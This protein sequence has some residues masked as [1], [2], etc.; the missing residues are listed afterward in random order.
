HKGENLKVKL[1]HQML[2]YHRVGTQQSQDIKIYER[3]DQPTWFVFGGVDESGRYLY[4]YT[5]KGTDKNEIYIADLGDP[6]HPNLRAA[7]RPVV[8]GHDA[9]YN[10]LGV[11][12]GK[13]YLQ[14]DKNAPNRKIV[15][16]PIANPV[17]SSWT[18]VIPEGD[19]PIEGAS[20]IA[21]RIG[22]LSLQDVASVVRLYSLNGKLEREVPMPGLGSASGLVGRYDHPELFYSFNSPTTPNTVYSYDATSNASTPFNPPKLTFDPSQ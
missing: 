1:E 17:P 22:V 6:M 4:I 18:T 5:S 19:L 16:A 11:A 9:N 20:L 13:L 2:Y 8:T 7:I 3:P 10:A 12:K 15:A 14:I 21:G